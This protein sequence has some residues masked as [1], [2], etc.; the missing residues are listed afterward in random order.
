MLPFVLCLYCRPHF[1]KRIIGSESSP[2]R[3]VAGELLKRIVEGRRGTHP[4]VLPVIE[5]KAAGVYLPAEEDGVGEPSG[6][7]GI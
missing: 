7:P 1:L 5:M 6:V 3:M 4:A 2:Y